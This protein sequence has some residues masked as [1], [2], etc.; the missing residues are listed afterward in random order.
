MYLYAILYALFFLLYIIFFV[1]LDVEMTRDF[2]NIVNNNTIVRM[3]NNSLLYE[4]N[5]RYVTSDAC[6]SLGNQV[7]FE[8]L[9]QK[10]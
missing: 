2:Y 10:I 9:L 1:Y 3:F 7:S 6:G 4:Q 8:I 5:L